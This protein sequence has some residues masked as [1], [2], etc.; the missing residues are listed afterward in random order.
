M[1]KI[2]SLDNS[3]KK[4]VLAQ[5]DGRL[6]A[7]IVDDEG[8]L[9]DHLWITFDWVTKIASLEKQGHDYN[10]LFYRAICGRKKQ[11]VSTVID[12]SLGVGGDALFLAFH[13]LK[14]IAFERDPLIFALVSDAH[15]NALQHYG[16][17]HWINHLQILSGAFPQ[18]FFD[19]QNQFGRSQL[20][21]TVVYYDPMYSQG[22]RDQ[23]KR[24]TKKEMQFLR[25]YFH[26]AKQAVRGDDR[27]EL[28]AQATKR[29]FQKF[30]FKGPRKSELLSCR[31][32]IHN[33]SLEGKTTRY[34]RYL[35]KS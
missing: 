35:A 34:D 16:K 22:K 31:Y 33:G 15:K 17:E 3:G 1:K 13:R 24:R 12:A 4:V 26:H 6:S 23:N 19:K 21:G 25:D 10:G 30:V 18:A 8:C 29:G 9:E 11:S 14:V 20:E 27:E 28:L 7:Q 5:V 32:A 2:I